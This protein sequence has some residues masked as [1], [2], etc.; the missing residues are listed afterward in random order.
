MT[1][2]TQIADQLSSTAA[3]ISHHF[4]KPVNMDT[5]RRALSVYHEQECRSNSVSSA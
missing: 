4:I 3:G 2:W 1:G 5:L